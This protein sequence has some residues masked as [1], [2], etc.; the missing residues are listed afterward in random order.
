MAEAEIKQQI[1]DKLARIADPHMGISIVDMGLV[2]NVEVE[3]K[4]AKITIKP[5][6]PGC[7]SVAN[8]AMAAKLEV[9]KLD[10]IDLAEIT[11]IDHMMADTINEM[12]NKEE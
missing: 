7:M 4:N 8:I 2:Q 5:T 3:D 1:N 9:E 11:V 10:E 6:N 12:I